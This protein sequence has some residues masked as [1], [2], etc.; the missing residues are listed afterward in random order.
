MKALNYEYYHEKKPH[1]SPRF[2]YNTYLCTIPLDFTHISTHWHDEL[3]LIIV[4][5][6]RGKIDVDLS[7]YEVKA[8]D[9]ILVLPGQLHSIGQLQ[10]QRMEYENI[11]FDTSLLYSQHPDVCTTDYLRP[12]FERHYCAPTHLHCGYPY[13]PDLYGCILELDDICS[14]R[15]PYYELYIKSILYRFFFLLFSNQPK[16]EI[17]SGGEK[18]IQRIKQVLLFVEK[19]YMNPIT[20]GDAAEH[21]NF[22]PSYFMKFF[23]QNMDMTFTEYLNDYRLTIAAKYLLE[24][25]ESILWVAVKCGFSN[26]SYFNRLFKKKFTVTPRQYRK[27]S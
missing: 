25:D 7:P 5:K 1:V 23:R 13:Y 27:Q 8:G 19:N 24:T 2:P 16:Q 17:N 14:R 6:G 11:L 18:N 26:L 9:I 21:L 10:G 4:K 15:A 3:E 22:S 12:F 20:L